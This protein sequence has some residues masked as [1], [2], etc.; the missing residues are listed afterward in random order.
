MCNEPPLL[1]HKLLALKAPQKKTFWK[2]I[3]QTI[4]R[5]KYFTVSKSFPLYI[6]VSGSTQIDFSDFILEVFNWAVNKLCLIFFV[7]TI[8]YYI[9]PYN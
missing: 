2:L 7:A 3:I 9:S 1:T 8:Y 5:Q 6:K 4:K